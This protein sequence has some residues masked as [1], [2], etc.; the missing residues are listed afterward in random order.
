MGKVIV[1]LSYQCLSFSAGPDQ[2]QMH[3]MKSCLVDVQN[4]MGVRLDEIY[5]WLDVV[6]IPQRSLKL[7]SLAVNT[8]YA[9]ARMASCLVIVAPE[10]VHADLQFR[11][12]VATYKRR[13]WCRAELLAFFCANGLTKMFMVTKAGSLQP[14][15][16][17]WMED[18]ANVFDGDLTCCTMKHAGNREC[19][20][21]SYSSVRPTILPTTRLSVP[22]RLSVRLSVHL[23]V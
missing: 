9:Y 12:S 15:M 8:L 16:D 19:D 14:V 6:A 2:E 4:Q 22:F 23:S 10:S 18:V 3:C 17:D 13:V 20:K 7:K 11:A 5:V 21:R 1:F